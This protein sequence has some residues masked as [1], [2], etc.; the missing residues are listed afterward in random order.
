M[1]RD[2]IGNHLLQAKSKYKIGCK[3][4]TLSVHLDLKNP[5]RS[6]TIVDSILKI[7][8]DYVVKVLHDVH[9]IRKSPR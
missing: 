9:I 6:R 3:T 5:G 4:I 2:K 7:P 1:V 8:N